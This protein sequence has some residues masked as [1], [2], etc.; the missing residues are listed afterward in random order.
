MNEVRIAVIGYGN[1]GR[2]QAEFLA[3]GKVRGGRLAAIV[4][5]S[6]DAR[7][8]AQ[9]RYKDLT[10]YESTEALLEA[11]AADA[12]IVSTPHYFH[13]PLA[14]MALERGVHAL[15]EKPAGAYSKQVLELNAVASRTGLVFG[16]MFQMRTSAAHQKMRSLLRSGELGQLRRF[17]Y[18]TTAWTRTQAYYDSGGWRATWEGEGGGVLLNQ[19]PHN[20]DILQWIT[21]MPSRVRAFCAFGKYHDIEVED[22][23]TGYFEY[24]NGATGVFITTTGEAPGTDYFEVVGDRGKLLYKD[25][26]LAFYRPVEPVSEFIKTSPGGFGQPE[27][28]TCD[29]ALAGGNGAIRNFDP[30]LG[31]EGRIAIITNFVDAIQNGAPLL[32]SGF[33]GINGT[34]LANAMLLSTW[35][36]GWVN[37]PLDHDYYYEMLQER[38]RN[39]TAKKDAS[40]LRTFDIT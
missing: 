20:I 16:I 8:A 38:I 34:Q 26:R 36:D 29:I 11:R 15:I 1:M 10:I 13:P 25:N 23:V 35:T 5:R 37:L 27:S 17:L 33:E 31:H 21:G 6:A 39:S 24:P 22:D 30:A 28:W 2:C 7:E 3:D 12:V 32:A 4:D 19:S 18:V 40:S 14:I 9:S